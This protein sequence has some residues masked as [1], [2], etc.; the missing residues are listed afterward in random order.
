MRLIVL[1]TGLL[2][3]I[4]ATLTAAPASASPQRVEAVGC[5][6]EFDAYLSGTT[7]VGTAYKD[8]AT[9]PTPTPL[10][11]TIQI[12]ACNAFGHCVWL[13]AKSGFGTVTWPCVAGSHARYR[14]TRIPERLVTC[15]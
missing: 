10:S 11:L 3:V 8:C 15:P 4:A 13:K 14:N 1:L 5:W 6:N 7:V 9:S 12:E 2:T